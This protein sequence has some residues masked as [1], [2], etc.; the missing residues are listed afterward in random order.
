MNCPKC[1][2]SVSPNAT[3]CRYCGM[4]MGVQSAPAGKICPTCGTRLAAQAKFC[5]KCGT[6]MDEQPKPLICTSCGAPLPSGSL[7]C[8][9]CG[10]RVDQTSKVPVCMGCGAQLAPD[11]LF[12]NLCGTPCAGVP[13]TPQKD[14]TTEPVPSIAPELLRNDEPAVVPEPKNLSA[15]TASL[16]EPVP[17]LSPDTGIEPEVKAIAK[18]ETESVAA[19][20]PVS[21]QIADIETLSQELADAEASGKEIAADNCPACGKVRIPGMAFCIN[22]GAL[23]STP[24][25]EPAVSAPEYVQETEPKPEPDITATPL[26]E[27]AFEEVAVPV[28]APA[29]DVC[30]VCGK[31]RIPGMVFCTGCG[32][33]LITTQAEP[34]AVSATEPVPEI[35]SK[36]EPDIMATPMQALAFAEVPVQTP[37]SA[38]GVCPTCGKERIPDMAFCIGCGA[39]LTQPEPMAAV[40]VLVPVAAPAMPSVELSANPLVIERIQMPEPELEQ[41]APA[42]QSICAA[43]GMVV[44]SGLR[45]CPRCGTKV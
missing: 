11:F 22:C 17:G 4:R 36:P 31:E 23:L 43:C 33:R 19:S 12:C 29:K 8:N 34:V 13:A 26:Q 1:G 2:N 5:S 14:E 42:W 40:P 38:G 6:R 20:D 39:R 3:F 27:L 35:E 44:A 21:E 7:F 16:T 45:N 28:P 10:G 24:Q 18:I 41:P 37:V 32:A 15:D 25:A 30:P 9:K